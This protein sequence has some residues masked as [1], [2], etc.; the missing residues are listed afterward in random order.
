MIRAI[1]V[2]Q[3]CLIQKPF[4][5][6]A[7]KS[8]V[9]FQIYLT[10]IINFLQYLLNTGFVLRISCTN[11]LVVLN[12]QMRPQF[13]KFLADFVNKFLWFNTGIGC[14][15]SDLL[16]MLICPCKKISFSSKQL[17]VA[18]QNICSNRGVCM[19]NMRMTVY[20]INWSCYVENV[21]HVHMLIMMN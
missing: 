13:A 20:V 14:R 21:I 10:L 6:Y 5:A 9:F 11:K 18:R 19:S 17:H 4:T 15:F 8:L 12:M 7:V 16:S 3:L 1:A 2:F